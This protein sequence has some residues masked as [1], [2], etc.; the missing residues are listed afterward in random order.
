MFT[1]RITLFEKYKLQTS[2][3]QNQSNL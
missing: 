3:T 1:T 2:R